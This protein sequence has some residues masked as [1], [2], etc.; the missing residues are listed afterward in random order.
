M[1]IVI[2]GIDCSGKS[3]ASRL[4]AKENN[5]VLY[6]TPP[7]DIIL[8]RDRVD[9]DASPLEHY[10]FYLGGIHTASRDIWELLASGKNVVCDR[11]WPTTYIYHKVMGV[12]VN[13]DDFSDVTKP[14]LTV[15]LLVSSEIQTRRF[16]D[17]GMSI[18]DRRMA[19]SQ[20]EL[21]REYRRVLSQLGIPQLV[22]NT[23]HNSPAEVVERI[24][25]DVVIRY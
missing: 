21:A 8:E 4:F 25:A 18:G 20:I 3:T 13:I 5:Y 12:D 23:D 24:Q 9:A 22:I 7:K 6:K 19:N 1:F 14:D 2:E 16:L 15:L 11:Y 17:R 10:R